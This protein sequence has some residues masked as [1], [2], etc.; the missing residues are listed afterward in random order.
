MLLV[1]DILLVN[2]IVIPLCD[3]MFNEKVRVPIKII[4]L[5]LTF[6][7]VMYWLIKGGV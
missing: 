3:L 5:C 1:V 7:W 6:I 4:I 2:F